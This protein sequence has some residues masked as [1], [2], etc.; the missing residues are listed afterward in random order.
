MLL[1]SPQGIGPQLDELI[2]RSPIGWRRRIQ[3][4]QQRPQI[5]LVV[6][7][8]H[9]APQLQSQRPDIPLGQRFLSR[10]PQ[11]AGLVGASHT[12]Q[13]L[14][15]G[16][17]A[18]RPVWV[19]FKATLE[20]GDLGIRVPQSLL[21]NGQPQVH[22]PALTLHLLKHKTWAQFLKFLGGRGPF[23]LGEILGGIKQFE[24]RR[25]ELA[26]G[27]PVANLLLPRQQLVPLVGQSLFQFGDHQ[28]GITP[29]VAPQC[30]HPLSRLETVVFGN[31]LLR[32]ELVSLL[33]R[34][35]PLEI[36]P[37]HQLQ[38]PQGDQAFHVG[39]PRALRPLLS[40]RDR[41]GFDGREVCSRSLGPARLI[42]LGPRQPQGNFSE[43][44]GVG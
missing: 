42:Q 3:A 33:Q 16:E 40:G 27:H 24:P 14:D 23:R 44:P 43:W 38:C 20:N 17:L 12:G 25:G 34:G 11:V 2:A 26:F 31:R 32:D 22:F 15:Q 36:L 35:P 41:L 28:Q 8:P 5:L 29:E 13:G 30:R 19:D 7:L 4:G 9:Q 21:A 18:L 10:H 6:G 1:Q 37:G 39:Q